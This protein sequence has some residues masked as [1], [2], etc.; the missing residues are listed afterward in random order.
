MQDVPCGF[1]RTYCVVAPRVAV[2]VPAPH[3]ARK[4]APPKLGAIRAE[5]CVIGGNDRDFLGVEQAQEGSADVDRI[6]QMDHMRVER[7]QCLGER[8]PPYVEFEFGIGQEGYA[9]C[10]I[11]LGAGIDV[12]AT[13]GAKQD[14]SMACG[15][16][17]L[18]KPCQR[19]SDTIH[20]GQEVF[21]NDGDTHCGL[22]QIG[23]RLCN[24]TRLEKKKKKERKKKR[25]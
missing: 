23:Q 2:S 22:S 25:A 20:F 14:D 5:I 15:L 13:L 21:C 16:K 19:T 9:C 18:Q 3:E 7:S 12:H 11:E 4:Q 17:M 10:A 8:R 6:Y 24:P 1:G